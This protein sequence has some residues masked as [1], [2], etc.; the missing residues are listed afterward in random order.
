MPLEK[1]FENLYF[2]KERE[3]I[4]DAEYDQYKSYLLGTEKPFI[5]FSR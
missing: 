3:L 2:L 5:G 4:T 1:Q